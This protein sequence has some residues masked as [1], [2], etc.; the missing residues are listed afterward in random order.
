MKT[1][2]L[3]RH[4]KSSWDYQVDDQDRPLKERGINDGHLVGSAVKS[5][6]I[7]IDAAFSS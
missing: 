6:N 2:I 4:G 7:S 3:V 1:L 5:M